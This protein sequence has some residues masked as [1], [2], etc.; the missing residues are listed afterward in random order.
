MTWCDR[1][2]DLSG[3]SLTDV[4]RELREMPGAET[5]LLRMRLTGRMPADEPVTV[6]DLRR[7]AENRFLACRIDA[8]QLVPPRVEEGLDDLLASP[9]LIETARAL[10]QIAAEPSASNPDTTPQ[11]ATRALEILQEIAWQQRQGSNA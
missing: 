10:E 4:M 8:A 9:Y 3:A 11:T 2:V 1:T 7:A 6:D 5:T